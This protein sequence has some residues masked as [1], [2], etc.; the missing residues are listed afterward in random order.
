MIIVRFN[1]CLPASISN[2]VATRMTACYELWALTWSP[3]PV[4][5]AAGYFAHLQ[6]MYFGLL[7]W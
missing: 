3:A 5:N 2:V 1:E 7:P 6:C 4:W